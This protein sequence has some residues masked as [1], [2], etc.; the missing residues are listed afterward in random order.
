MNIIID[1]P[2]KELKKAV[3]EKIANVLTAPKHAELWDTTGWIE[4]EDDEIEI[5]VTVWYESEY[6]SAEPDVGGS[7]GYIVYILGAVEEETGKAYDYSDREEESW[8]E[9]IS[10]SIGGYRD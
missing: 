5:P 4:T 2:N 10:E 6:V 8:S 3:E 1:M 9:E 7:A